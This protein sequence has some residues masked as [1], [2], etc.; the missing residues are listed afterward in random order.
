M[1]ENTSS[2]ATKV[3]T[4][5]NVSNTPSNNADNNKRN[6][7][8]L[9][10]VIAVLIVILGALTFWYFLPSQKSRSQMASSSEASFNIDSNAKFAPYK[11]IKSNVK[12][13]L[14]PYSLKSTELTNL[15]EVA[16]DAKLQFSPNQLGSFETNGF[17]IQ[18]VRPEPSDPNQILG[19]AGGGRAD[20]M[21][22]MYGKWG[23][24]FIIYDRK[25]ENAVFIT[26]DLLLHTYHL[27][28]DRTFAK[29]EDSNF[30]P[31]LK[32]LT[33]ALYED[34]IARYSKENS[35]QLKESLKRVS[36]FY[37]VPLALLDSSVPKP[38]DH[39]SSEEEQTKFTK[40]DENADSDQNIKAS[41]QKYKA[42][43]PTEIFDLA[44]Q[45]LDLVVKAQ[46]ESPSP[47]YGKFK[48][49]P[50]VYSQY[51]PR[52]H[53]TKNS[54]LRSYFRAMMWYGR[55]G[56]EVK[57]IDLTRDA[58]IMTWQL[59]SVKVKGT[60][61]DK[62]W[63]SIYLPTTFF[64]G[65]T[66]DLSI[67]DYSN[68]MTKIY[69]NSVT[70]TSLSDEAKLQE[71]QQQAQKL[72]GPKI[73]SEIKVFDPNNAPSKDALL[74]STKGFRFMG[75][76]FTPDAFIF[77]SLTQ[78]DEKPDAETGQKLPSTP[79]GLM[80]MSVLGSNTADSLLNDWIKDNA[81]Q[82]DKVITKVKTNLKGQFQKLD[83][84][85][86]TQNIYWA[87]LYNL[88]P[89]FDDHNDGYPM[90]MRGMPWSKKSLLAAF[91]S[92]TE[93]KHD[94]LLYAKQSFAER[95]AGNEPR[96]IPPVPKGYVEPNLPF[97]TRLI[98]LANMTEDGLAS[99]GLID[100]ERKD[101]FDRFTETLNFFKSIAEK[102]LSNSKISDDDYEKLRLI[103]K[104]DYPS[105]VWVPDFDIMRERDARAGIIAD[106][107][108]DAIKNQVLY[109][110]TGY[111][112]IIYVAVK[113]QGGTRLTRGVVY[114]Y[115]EFTQPSASRIND[116]EWQGM[117]YE[118][119][120]S[121][122]LPQSPNWTNELVK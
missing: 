99:K 113:D 101:K 30:Q 71:F 5:S 96:E 54:L 32:N 118:G 82:S 10:V 44:S 21:V 105:I 9:Y 103:V 94:T 51:K 29:I 115:Y 83:Q 20:D 7:K 73:L 91:G 27:L 25:P 38:K 89:L 112:S 6:L 95:G 34:S 66:D 110:A 98:A 106:V 37:L 8:P 72:E 62:V 79:T 53:Y 60:P 40:N 87:W 64:V 39:F 55:H 120:N 13:V 41:L 88:L 63:E 3:K 90:F 104:R 76:R 18:P 52:G 1:N 68:L 23:G 49:G 121:G 26:S 65:K 70:Y 15:N 12:P 33:K 111:P 81:P 75:Q 84:S 122:N 59:G 46:G 17:F 42:T 14:Q 78:G 74:Q 56:F 19:D 2:N 67:Y 45:E 11:E 93:L 57:S 100:Q 114:S 107:H 92:W 22:D 47:L 58:A 16:T 108:T 117:I 116:E 102:E 24:S 36:V 119:K 85:T 48:D 69:G 97:L 86:W 43:A 61:V 31:S 4:D 35:P 77:S 80:V 109:E 50:E 28:I